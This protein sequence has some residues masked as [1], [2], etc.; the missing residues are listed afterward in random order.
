MG[1]LGREQAMNHV[2]ERRQKRPFALQDVF[3]W[4]ET[5]MPG[6]H[7]PGLHGIRI[8][9]RSTADA[10]IVSAELPGIDP[11]KDVEVTVDND[12]LTLRAERTERAEDVRHSEFRYG[13]FSRSLRLP[14]GARPD[15]ASA[16]YR[17]G[18][19][20]IKVPVSER[21]AS[22]RKITVRHEGK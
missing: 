19:L 13:A 1:A 21:A 14:S 16:D 4:F 15:E 22:A 9:E 12:M 2:V 5:S 3:D 8:E 7:P 11:D 10:F 18:V 20:T 6:L 17:S